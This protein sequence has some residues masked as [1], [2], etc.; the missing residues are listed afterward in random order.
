M[1]TENHDA[2]KSAVP[3]TPRA[4]MRE[5]VLGDIRRMAAENGGRA[6]GCH[7]FSRVTGLTSALWHGLIWARWSD[8]V[9]DAGLVPNGKQEKH[10]DDVL[11][12]ALA[13]VARHFGRIPTDAESLLYRES[14]APMPTV[15]TYRR[16]F[17]PKAALLW[18]M[19]LWAGEH[20]DRADIRKML[21]HIEDVEPAM[22]V[23]SAGAVYLLRAG[24]SYKIGCSRAPDRRT[25]SIAGL[26]PVAGNV[27]HVI[28]TDDPYGVEQYWHRRFARKRTRGEWFRLAAEDVAAF[29]SRRVM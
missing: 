20:P 23:R 18:R 1:Q 29:R 17:G 15:Q 11:L 27:V 10:D 6:P 7:R 3:A 9:R 19:K 2:S 14:R 22:P 25:K 12:A 4:A 13:G 16:H 8:A 26:L 28:E 5:R 21:R 24:P